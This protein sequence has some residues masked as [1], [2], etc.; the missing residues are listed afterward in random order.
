MNSLVTHFK[1][2]CV[3]GEREREGIGF[4]DY[5]IFSSPQSIVNQDEMQEIRDLVKP[6]VNLECIRI[7]SQVGS[8]VYPCCCMQIISFLHLPTIQTPGA[9][10]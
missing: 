7:G 4:E 6:K 5:W 1:C 3:C 9:E 10:N 2:V 8:L